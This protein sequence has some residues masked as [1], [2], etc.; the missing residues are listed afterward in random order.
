MRH[1]SSILILILCGLITTE[2][3]SQ[4]P[5]AWATLSLVTKEKSYDEFMGM[6]MEK[7]TPTPIAQTMDGKEIEV[8]GYM[9]ALDVKRK[10]SHIM[11][12]RYPQN[13]CFFCGAAGPESAMQVFMAGGKELE[14]TTDKIVLKGILNV[15]LNDP[16]GLIYTLTQAEYVSKV[17]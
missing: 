1:L 8:R 11:F 6:E 15:Q 10:Q 14:H 13:M 3:L 2:C 5:D 16:T 7:V 9:I 17:K 12:S 4:Q